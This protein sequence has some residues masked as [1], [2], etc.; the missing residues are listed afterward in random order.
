MP[1]ADVAAK[2]GRLRVTIRQRRW[3]LGIKSHEKQ[4]QRAA[5]IA[6]ARRG[7]P[8]PPHVAEMLRTA[9]IGKKHTEEARRK[10]S[11]ANLRQGRRKRNGRPFSVEEDALLGTMTD[12]EAA[13][14]T[15]RHHATIVARRRLLGIASYRRQTRGW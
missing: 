5:K 8:R 6:A 15:G 10:M 12:S 13:A 14:Q 2:T 3:R 9:Q 1:D 7:K 4:R 11:E